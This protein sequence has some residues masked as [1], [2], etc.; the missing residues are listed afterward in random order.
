MKDN[1]NFFRGKAFQTNLFSYLKLN[2]VTIL[3]DEYI[4]FMY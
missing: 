1:K 2:L 3:S 4:G